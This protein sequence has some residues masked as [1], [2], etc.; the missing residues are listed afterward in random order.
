MTK[1]CLM[2]CR[3]VRN[4][5]HQMRTDKPPAVSPPTQTTQP[6]QP[7]PSP[8]DPEAAAASPATALA[9]HCP[10]QVDS[11]GV[12][13]APDMP[14]LDSSSVLLPGDTVPAA[15]PLAGPPFIDL[16]INMSMAQ[17]SQMVAHTTPMHEL[18]S[19]QPVAVMVAGSGPRKSWR[20]LRKQTM[21]KGD[22]A[23]V[24]AMAG[25]PV[26]AFPMFQGD[27]NASPEWERFQC[28]IVKELK[29]TCMQHG[30]RFPSLCAIS[31]PYDF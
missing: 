9:P 10:P 4:T 31:D 18:F 5:L 19:L 20:K 2:V 15:S 28:G 26:Q 12:V 13:S 1:D 17:H 27:S 3:L 22:L 24:M 16:S 6:T 25:V 29:A 11:T 23:T 30:L 7:L 21:A 14:S 8:P